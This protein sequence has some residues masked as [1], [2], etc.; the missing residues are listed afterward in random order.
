M[1]ALRGLEKRLAKRAR[2]ERLVLDNDFD[3]S[4]VYPP[5]HMKPITTAPTDVAE[6]DIYYNGTT[7]TI[8][9]YT[10]AAFESLASADTSSAQTFAGAVTVTGALVGSSTLAITGATTLSSTLD[11]TGAITQTA[12][13]NYLRKVHVAPATLTAAD[14]GALCVFDTA[15][16]MLYTLPAAAAGL[17]FDFEV[18]A[19][20]TSGVHRIACAAGDF[21]VGTIL[22]IID[23]TFA[24]TARTADGTTHL[25]WEGNGSTTGGLIG[26]F[27]RV[28]AISASQWAVSGINTAT[29]AE[30][31]P[32]K[33]T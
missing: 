25:A 19:S 18:S 15:A 31:T 20:C 9:V 27:I 23:T 33:T 11:V 22:Q 2:F 24:P 32:F 10:G 5:L 13:S 3:V 6:G 12:Q 8:E 26:D 1:T 16:G 28:T 4:P 29:G 14:S 17:W 7:N 30:A 21:L